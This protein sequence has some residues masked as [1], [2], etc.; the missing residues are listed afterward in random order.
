MAAITVFWTASSFLSFA[1]VRET[2]SVP[3][4]EDFAWGPTTA[5][6]NGGINENSGYG[7]VCYLGDRCE[8]TC[9]TIFANY[10]I[11]GIEN[12]RFRAAYVAFSGRSN[13]DKITKTFLERY[14]EPEES[15]STPGNRF[16]FGENLN[17]HLQYQAGT[18]EG[19]LALTYQEA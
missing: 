1:S 8:S 14:G 10:L 4:F 5:A 3:K 15:G 12:E 16:W 19:I 7:Y 11:L 6:T 9:H 13:F 2:S 18:D 17:V